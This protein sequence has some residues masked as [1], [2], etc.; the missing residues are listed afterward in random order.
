LAVPVLRS[1]LFFVSPPIAIGL[2]ALLGIWIFKPT[3]SRPV[4]CTLR[5]WLAIATTAIIL[6]LCIAFSNHLGGERDFIH[7]WS[8]LLDKVRFFGTKPLDPGQLDYPARSLWI[9]A[10]NSPGL[11]QVFIDF[12]PTIIFSVIGFVLFLKIRKRQFATYHF[13][14]MSVLFLLLYLAIERMGIVANFFICILAASAGTLYTELEQIHKTPMASARILSAIGLVAT[15]IF[16]SYQGLMLN[17][18]TRYVEILRKLFG[19]EQPSTISNSR[20]NDIDLVYFIR[21]RTE[22]DAIFLARYGVEPLI[23]AYANRAIALQPKFEVRGSKE[24]VKEYYETIYD[25]EEKLYELCRTWHITYL[26]HDIKIALDN[27]KDSDR[28]VA[29]CLDLPKSSVAFSMQFAPWKLKH[30]ELVYESYFYRLFRVLPPTET[31]RGPAIQ[32][33]IYDVKQFGDQNL[34]GGYF[35]DCFTQEVIMRIRKASNLLQSAQVVMTRDPQ[36]ALQMMIESRNLYPMLIGSATTLGV[37]YVLLDEL[38]EGLKLCQMEV[39]QN[40]WFPLARYNLAY[41]LINAGNNEAA[42]KELEEALRLD[43]RFEPARVLLCQVEL[44]QK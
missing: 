28:W 21:E 37:I 22:P 41:G 13:L 36:R 42:K 33:S 29:D 17:H 20:I 30:F 40:P 38:K 34:E 35:N 26:L 2:G 7:V 27:T 39:E 19:S 14:I 1:K 43:P 16:N 6:V 24:K 8:L 3:A 23:L 15:L 44:M 32:Q 12:F 4:F 5:G 25:N 18:Q 31:A 10:F 9:E 11:T